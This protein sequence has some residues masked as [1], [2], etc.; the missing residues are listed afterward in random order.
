MREST[1]RTIEERVRPHLEEGEKVRAVAPCFLGPRGALLFGLL[2][3]LFIKQKLAVVTDRNVYL[4]RNSA[5]SVKSPK[6]I[7]ARHPL[8]SVEVRAEKGLPMGSLIIGDQRTSVGKLYQ[9]DAE[10]VARAA[11]GAPT[12]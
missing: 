12:E 8:G 9:G 1:R 7:E 11:S 4:F 2:G 10:E 5:L 3:M 6:E